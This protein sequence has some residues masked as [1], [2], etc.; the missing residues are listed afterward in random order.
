MR[1]IRS[2]RIESGD[3]VTSQTLQVYNA[4]EDTKDK[5]NRIGGSERMRGGG[6]SAFALEG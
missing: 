3:Q 4:R 5:Q 2:Q 1:R 6:A